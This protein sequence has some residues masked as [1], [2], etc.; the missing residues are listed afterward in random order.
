MSSGYHI[1][2]QHSTYFVTFTL[3]GW[4]DLFT[5]KECKDIIIG[6]LQYCQKNKGLIIY[7][8]VLMESHLHLVAT[9]KDGSKGLS[10]IIRDFKKFTSLKIIDW[11]NDNPTESRRDWLKMVFKYHGKYNQ[12]NKHFQVWQQHN[13]PKICLQPKF[14]I[15][16]INYIHNNPVVTG[17]VDNPADYRYSSARNYEGRKDYI[18]DVIVLDYGPQVGYVRI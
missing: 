14:T 8:Y 1:S 10:A 9:A 17:I 16:K 4:L 12:N 3:V 6:S 2:D 15:Q 5:R 18:L 7:A 11:I 13:M